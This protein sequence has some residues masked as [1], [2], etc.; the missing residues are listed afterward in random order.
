[1]L[2]GVLQKWQDNQNSRA[3]SNGSDRSAPESPRRGRSPAR[4][5]APEAEQD[6]DGNSKKKKKQNKKKKDTGPEGQ[7]D[8]SLAR[9]LANMAI[10]APSKSDDQVFAELRAL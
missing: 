7:V 5:S 4:A 3:S 10:S 2:I 6:P 9:T 1:M 8:T